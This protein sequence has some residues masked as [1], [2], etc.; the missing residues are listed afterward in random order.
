MFIVE[1][2]IGAGKTTLLKSIAE[3]LPHITVAFEPL[4]A[5]HR[6]EAGTSLLQKFYEDPK[7]WAFSIESFAMA[8]RVIEHLQQQQTNKNPFTISE[9]SIFSG[10]YCFAQNSY[11]SGLMTELEWQ[12][13]LQWFNFLIPGKCELPRG[14]IYLRTSPEVAFERIQQR[15]K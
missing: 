9:R 2:N 13:Y 6:Q 8:C 4:N 14:F 10:H 5:W 11:T 7:R 1:A 15:G 12:L 3:R